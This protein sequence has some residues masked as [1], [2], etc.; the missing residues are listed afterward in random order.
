MMSFVV[1][2]LAE[3]STSPVHIRP[4][5]DVYVGCLFTGPECAVTSS[6]ANGLVGTVFISRYRLQPRAGF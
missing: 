6:L 1:L 2:I 4:T 5:I 3:S